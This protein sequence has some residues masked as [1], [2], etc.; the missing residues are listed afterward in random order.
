VSHPEAVA[1]KLLDVM[2]LFGFYQ[3]LIFSNIF[4]QIS[5]TFCTRIYIRPIFLDELSGALCLAANN[6][7]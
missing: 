1:S 5:V 6:A 4:V 2:L 3:T 7:D